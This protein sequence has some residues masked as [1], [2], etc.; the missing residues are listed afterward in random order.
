MQLDLSLWLDYIEQHIGFILPKYQ[1]QWLSNAINSTAQKYQLDYDNLYE[2]VQKN[3]EMR[4]TLFD[5]VLI[6]ESR[7]FRDL[8]ALSFVAEQY[9]IHLKEN[10]P[11]PF[12][13]VSVGCA[14]GQ[15][16]W[17]LAM[18]L[19][20][21]YRSVRGKQIM[22][23]A[24]YQILGLDVSKTSLEVAKTAFYHQISLQQIPEE[25]HIYIRLGQHHGEQGWRPVPA[26]QNHTDFGWCN[27]F[28]V[29]GLK[30]SLMLSGKKYQNPHIIICQNVL[31]YFRRFDQRDILGRFVEL[32][33]DNGHLILS[34]VDGTFWRHD[35]MERLHY[36]GANIW[37]KYPTQTP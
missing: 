11:E 2:Q 3:D 6:A 37:Y 35:Q 34:A 4:Q 1:H 21:T 20:K 24:N 19:E 25:Y 9:E 32:L 13:V 7:F 10:R 17:S 23:P 28:L 26:L 16:V 22:T 31:I 14:T 5:N 8:G 18:V 27:V 15:E 30:N 36:E 29:D 12:S 33:N